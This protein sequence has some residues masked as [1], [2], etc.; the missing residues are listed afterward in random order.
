MTDRKPAS[1]RAVSPQLRDH[2]RSLRREMTGAERRLWWELRNRQVA[3][4]RFRRQVPIDGF[5][6]D[7][8]C[9]EAR[10]I[11]EIDGA[12]HSTA[13]EVAHDH[14]R[15]G[16]L[17]DCGYDILRV[18]NAEIYGNLDGVLETIRLKLIEAA[19]YPPP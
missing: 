16:R 11:I 13:A 7:F 6:V 5:I 10:L 14:R 8:A 18:R 12:T 19:S 15:E 17:R 4:F 3:G 1:H 9:H 2:V